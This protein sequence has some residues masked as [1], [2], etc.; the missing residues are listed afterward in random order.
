MRCCYS[1][2]R[3]NGQASTEYVLVASAMVGI[4]IFLERSPLGL[5]QAMAALFQRYAFSISLPW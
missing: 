4:W 2:R 1:I 5:S 3:P